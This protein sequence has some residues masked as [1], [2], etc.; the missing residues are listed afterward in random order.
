[1]LASHAV[2]GGGG[3]GAE[4]NIIYPL[5]LRWKGNSLTVRGFGLIG[6]ITLWL[7]LVIPQ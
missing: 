3:S 7:F 2:D 1:M 5:S 4:A 6:K